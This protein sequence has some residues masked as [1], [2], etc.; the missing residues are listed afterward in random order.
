M[1][2]TENS[3]P[4][5]SPP[6]R[7]RSTPRFQ[8]LPGAAKPATLKVGDKMKAIYRYKA[9]GS[10]GHRGMVTKTDNDGQHFT[11]L[12]KDDDVAEHVSRS[13]IT[14]SKSKVLDKSPEM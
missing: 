6:R 3:P 14:L 12:Y 8:M 9:G 2:P 13:V 7:I 1:S 11:I 10:R 5:E 4:V